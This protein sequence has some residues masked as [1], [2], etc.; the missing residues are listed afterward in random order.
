MLSLDKIIIA[1]YFAILLVLA[2]YGLHRYYLVYLYFKHKDQ[3]RRPSVNFTELPR[4]TVQL[5]IFNESCVV[6]RLIDAVLQLDYPKDK[7]EIQVLDD[8]TDET[9]QIAAAKVADAQR[10]GFHIEYLHR[11]NRAGFKAGALAAGLARAQGAYVAIFDADFLPGPDM[12]RETVHY[13]TDPKVGMV[14]VRWGHINRDY[15]L[16]TRLQSILLDGHFMIEHTARNR[17]GRFFNF[18]GTAGIWRRACIEDAGGW[19]H[20]TL[21]EDLDL[22]YRAQLRDWR[23]VYL[24]HV[25]SPAELPVEMSAF[26]SQQHRW[27]KGSIQTSMKVL[28]RIWRSDLP[29]KIKTEATFHLTSNVAYVLMILLA[30]LML[31][32]LLIRTRYEDSVTSILF[33]LSIFMAATSSVL[34]FY[35][36]SQKEIYADWRSQIKYFPALLSL[37]IGL[38]INNAKAVLEALLR[39]QSSFVRTPKYN[40]IGAQRRGAARYR[41]VT[42]YLPVAIEILFGC[43]FLLITAIAVSHGLLVTSFFLSLFVAGFFYVGIGSMVSPGR[44]SL[45]RA[46]SHR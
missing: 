24:P 22:S 15:S 9:A 33:D 26:K 41:G 32:A 19:Q 18:N 30:L 40:V 16:L 36:V 11:A 12:L 34:S 35:T 1:S 20:D 42:R 10:R 21:T 13:F 45:A 8:S 2:V 46:A 38:A 44:L 25:V 28:P 7:L 43:Y 14:Q 23:F 31:P 29:L 27:A 3:V 17:S 4:V 5:P 39:R 6:E 37:G